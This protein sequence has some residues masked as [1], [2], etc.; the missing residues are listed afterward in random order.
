MDRTMPYYHLYPAD[1]DG[2]VGYSPVRAVLVPDPASP[3][4]LFLN[5][6]AT[7]APP[8]AMVRVFKRDQADVG[9]ILRAPPSYP[10]FGRR[11]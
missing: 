1:T 3:L 7:E 2:P 9:S 10:R 8:G 4:V 6:T 5:P 11:A